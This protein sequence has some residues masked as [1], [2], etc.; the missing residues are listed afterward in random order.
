M[1]LLLTL[2]DLLGHTLGVDLT[3]TAPLLPVL[4]IAGQ[5]PERSILRGEEKV[6]LALEDSIEDPE[7]VVVTG[8]LQAVLIFPAEILGRHLVG[9]HGLQH[10][11]L[12]RDPVLRQPHPAVPTF[13]ASGRNRIFL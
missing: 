3:Q 6:S 11:L 5:I 2:T 13:P 1:T 10:H 7:D 9:V 12:P 4:D 8:Q